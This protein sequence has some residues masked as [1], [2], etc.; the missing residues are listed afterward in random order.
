MAVAVGDLRRVVA[1]AMRRG[2]RVVLG[3]RGSRRSSR[4]HQ[5]ARSGDERGG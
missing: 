5:A 4:R 3:G 2:R 1:V